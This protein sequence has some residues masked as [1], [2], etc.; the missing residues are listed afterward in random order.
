MLWRCSHEWCVPNW[1]GE[2]NLT[3]C[4]SLKSVRIWEKK[5]VAEAIQ[6]NRHVLRAVAVI[7]SSHQYVIC[8][9]FEKMQTTPKPLLKYLVIPC[10][11]LYRGA[12]LVLR[13]PLQAAKEEHWDPRRSRRPSVV[14]QTKYSRGRLADIRELLSELT[15]MEALMQAP[16][17]ELQ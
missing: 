3:L 4:Y 12:M 6:S 9:Y 16:F 5:W 17:R 1:I 10:A 11:H 7:Q 15:S 13:M 2:A 14:L 8:N